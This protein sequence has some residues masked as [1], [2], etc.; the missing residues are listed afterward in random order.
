[1]AVA[2]GHAARSP[3]TVRH[4]PVLP[5]AVQDLARLWGPLADPLLSWLGPFAGVDDPQVWSSSRLAPGGF[6]VEVSFCSATPRT[7]R[8]AA[9][10]S[11]YRVLPRDRLDVALARLGRRDVPAPQGLAAD[12]MRLVAEAQRTAEDLAWGAWVGARTDVDSCRWK[13]YLEIPRSVAGV[14]QAELLGLLGGHGL[15]VPRSTLRMLALDL[16]KSA[17]ASPVIERYYLVGGL[18]PQDVRAIGASAGCPD[19]ADE[20][21]ALAEAIAAR[22]LHVGLP[23]GRH[24]VSLRHEPSGG[25]VMSVI[26]PARRWI[27]HDPAIRDRLLALGRR[28]GDDTAPYEQLTASCAVLDRRAHGLITLSCGADRA[29]RWTVGMRPMQTSFSMSERQPCCYASHLVEREIGL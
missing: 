1:M 21:L 3:G 29:A 14:V 16:P 15:P 18:S 24:R 22:P 5:A 27:G 4:N 19:A 6:P 7:A 13:V 12:L 8:W 23:G 9:D 25:V 17:R 28:R 10:P 20:V 26:A 2:G 11:P